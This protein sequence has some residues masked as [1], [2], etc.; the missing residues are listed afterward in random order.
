MRIHYS[1]EI[2]QGRW[3]LPTSGPEI[4]RDGRFYRRCPLRGP[5]LRSLYPCLARLW[6]EGAGRHM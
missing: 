1:P 6:R 3:V 5:V 4:H 2:D